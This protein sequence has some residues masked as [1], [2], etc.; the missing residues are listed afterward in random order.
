MT[1]GQIRN[2]LSI[3]DGYE[4]WAREIVENYEQ[5]RRIFGKKC[6]VV[7]HKDRDEVAIKRHHREYMREYMRQY[8]RN[9]QRKEVQA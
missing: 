3:L 9:R 6:V 8:R 2:C 4:S 1:P 7:P 5:S